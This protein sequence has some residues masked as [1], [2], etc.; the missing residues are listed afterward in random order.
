VKISPV[1]AMEIPASR[2]YRGKKAKR[3]P[4]AYVEKNVAVQQASTVGFLVISRKSARRFPDSGRRAG[5]GTGMRG[6]ARRRPAP[7]TTADRR[8]AVRNPSPAAAPPSPGPA[9][10]PR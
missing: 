3:E 1:W 2:A 7:M 8:N 10:I 4:Q 5:G 6:P 9:A